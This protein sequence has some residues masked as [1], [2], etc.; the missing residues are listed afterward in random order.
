VVGEE[1]TI[2]SFGIQVGG[3]PTIRHR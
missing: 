2:S 1:T 3:V